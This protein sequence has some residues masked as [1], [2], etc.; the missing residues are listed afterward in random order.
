M[1][2]IW[3]YQISIGE[4]LTIFLPSPTNQS[5]QDN[6]IRQMEYS[7]RITHEYVLDTYLIRDKLGFEE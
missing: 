5:C 7:V 1:K 2:S 6:P 4:Y 3:T